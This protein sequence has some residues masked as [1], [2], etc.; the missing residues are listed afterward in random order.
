MIRKTR[1]FY[2]KIETNQLIYAASEKASAIDADAMESYIYKIV[3][4]KST[5]K[6]NLIIKDMNKIWKNLKLPQY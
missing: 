5:R 2:N 4:V 6:L 1:L 3:N